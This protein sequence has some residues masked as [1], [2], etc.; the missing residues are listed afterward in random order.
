[1]LVKIPAVSATTHI[2]EITGFAPESA[3]PTHK[4]SNAQTGQRAQDSV[5]LEK[6]DGGELGAEKD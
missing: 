5:L 3:T 4:R 6:Y 2:Y 1:M